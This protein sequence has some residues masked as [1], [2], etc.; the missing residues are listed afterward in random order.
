M[1]AKSAIE[2][3]IDFVKEKLPSITVGAKMDVT[4][5]PRPTIIDDDGSST[6]VKPT[7][8]PDATAVYMYADGNHMFTNVYGNVGT[9]A[10][11]IWIDYPKPPDVK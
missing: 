9:R 7:R 1:T 6:F 11:S 2:V 4:P 10:E 5:T 8:S 3:F